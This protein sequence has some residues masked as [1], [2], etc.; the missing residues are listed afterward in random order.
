[1][2]QRIIQNRLAHHQKNGEAAASPELIRGT[3]L[4][5]V[6]FIDWAEKQGVRS[7][8]YRERFKKYAWNVFRNVYFMQK[9]APQYVPK[10]M[11]SEVYQTFE[12]VGQFIQSRGLA[13]NPMGA[14][15]ILDT[16]LQLSDINLEALMAS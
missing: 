11:R 10:A 2:S 14:E 9:Y 8:Y 6:E 4:A 7:H 1:M 3:L 5:A 15:R 16:H 13:S 12:R